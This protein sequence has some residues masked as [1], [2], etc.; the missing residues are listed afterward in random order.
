MVGSLLCTPFRGVLLLRLGDLSPLSCTFPVCGCPHFAFA[1]RATSRWYLHLRCTRG[2]PFELI[3]SRT[4][5]VFVSPLFSLLALCSVVTLGPSWR[6]PVRVP[7]LCCLRRS[8]YLHD[9]AL[10]VFSPLWCVSFFVDFV[11]VAVLIWW[12]VC[13]DYLYVS[14]VP[15]RLPTVT[16]SSLGLPYGLFWPPDGPVWTG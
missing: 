1:F 3:G 15:H 11:L 13:V 2:S 10:A 12:A 14:S 16:L 4:I 8:P 7:L 6:S 9:R 5:V